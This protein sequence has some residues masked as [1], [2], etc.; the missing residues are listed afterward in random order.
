MN[1]QSIINIL[2]FLYLKSSVHFHGTARFFNFCLNETL[3]YVLC[4][5]SIL[6]TIGWFIGYRLAWANLVI[7]KIHYW[8]TSTVEY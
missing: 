2:I 8:S 5:L 3:F 4:L 7:G 6:K 1:D